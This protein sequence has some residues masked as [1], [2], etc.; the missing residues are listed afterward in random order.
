[1][2]PVEEQRAAYVE[3]LHEAVGDMPILLVFEGAHQP[4]VIE[5]VTY[6]VAGTVQGV[7]PSFEESDTVRPSHRNSLPVDV[8]VYRAVFAE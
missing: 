4:P 2:L 1:M 6:E 5:G 3:K 8:T 7:I